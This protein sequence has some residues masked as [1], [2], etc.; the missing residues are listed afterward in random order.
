MVK[1]VSFY[2]SPKTI[3]FFDFDEISIV[4]LSGL[5]LY[6]SLK[7]TSIFRGVFDNERLLFFIH[8]GVGNSIT[9][10]W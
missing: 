3:L 5:I 10:K 4:L 7:G 6:K 8:M 9:R 1:M 2:L